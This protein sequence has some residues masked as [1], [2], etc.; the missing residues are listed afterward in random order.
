M[1]TMINTQ[2]ETKALQGQNFP[3]IFKICP[4][5]AFRGTAVFREVGY[6][7]THKYFL[8][9]SMYNE[10][11]YGWAGH[12]NDSSGPLSTVDRVYNK[13]SMFRPEDII[14]SINIELNDASIEKLNHSHVLLKRINYAMNCF[15]LNL[16]EFSEEI[17]E[18]GVKTMTFYFKLA[19]NLT[20][21]QINA[22]GFYLASYRDFFDHSFYSFGDA[23]AGKPG[24]FTKYGFEIS[25]N[26]FVEH[27]PSK[28]CQ[29]YPTPQFESFGDC[30]YQYMLDLCEKAG[31]TPIWLANDFTNVSKNF[32][33]QEPFPGNF[34]VGIVFH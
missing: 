12:R 1:P 18:K 4:L 25:E 27:D 22:Q 23:V 3:L 26:I 24:Y 8:G 7:T 30:D 28:N 31:V 17:K 9:R 10:S 11:I 16:D 15:T 21:V 13:V 5:P 33:F 19:A 32:T 14:Q 34:G 6:K 20:R 29:V 2:V